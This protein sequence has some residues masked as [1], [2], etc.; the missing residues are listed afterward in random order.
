M[1]KQVSPAVAIG[2][3]AVAVVA[4]GYF[5][6]TRAIYHGTP[7]KPGQALSDPALRKAIGQRFREGAGSSG[8]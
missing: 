2:V 3:I 7:F 6:Y 5:F 4:L 8:N 1:Q